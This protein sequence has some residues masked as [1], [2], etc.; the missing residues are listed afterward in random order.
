MKKKL[1]VTRK[2]YRIAAVLI[3]ALLLSACGSTVPEGEALAE[4]S[5]SIGTATQIETDITIETMIAVSEV[6]AETEEGKAEETGEEV[7]TALET[8]ADQAEI[9]DA[10]LIV[11]DAGHQGK[12]DPT[13]EPIG[14][15]AAE[16]KASVASGTRGVA[17]GLA[18]YELTLQVSGL[19]E[20]ELLARGYQVIMVRRTHD[21]NISNSERAKVA[22]DH[23]ADAL[24]RIHANGSQNAE[25]QG[26]MTI[27]PTPANPYCGDIYEQCRKLSEE[28]LDGMVQETGARSEGVWETDTM[29]GINWSQVP[30]TI[31]E[32]GYMTNPE[33]DMKMAD[34]AYQQQ[35]VTGIA[36]G[37]DA[38]ILSR[39]Q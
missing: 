6:R 14:P 30:V 10:P 11:I 28:V 16:Q 18:E 19:L 29:S 21:V 22:N 37:I 39:Y 12:G 15:G 5:Q 7:Q 23:E 27:S 35:I 25:V 36:N 32:M 4:T 38:Y 26:A 34:A 31:V 8:E 1:F 33:E 20:Q 17:S 24:I 3:C 9:S 13:K 2:K